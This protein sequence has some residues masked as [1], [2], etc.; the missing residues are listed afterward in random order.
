MLFT[1]SISLNIFCNNSHLKS[2]IVQSETM[3][4]SIVCLWLTWDIYDK[5]STS[6]WFINGKYGIL[7]N[8]AIVDGEAE[9]KITSSDSLS[10]AV[11]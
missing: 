10:N 8:V 1:V 5:Y 11:S 7:G 6:D 4:P 9:G 2:V 3:H